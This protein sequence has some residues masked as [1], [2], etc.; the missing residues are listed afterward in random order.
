MNTQLTVTI[1]CLFG[2]EES[3]NVYKDETW[4]SS[5]LTEYIGQCVGNSKIITNS[6]LMA[7]KLR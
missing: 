4:T 2:R 5:P 1:D 3:C 7:N 6:E